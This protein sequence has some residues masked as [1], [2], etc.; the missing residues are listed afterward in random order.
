MSAMWLLQWLLQRM[1]V[2]QLT[3]GL[4]PIA[5]LATHLIPD[6]APLRS[7]S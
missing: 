6:L 7:V 4:A 1:R 2:T 3:A 5:G